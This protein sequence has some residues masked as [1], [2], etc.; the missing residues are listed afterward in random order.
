MRIETTMIEIK[1]IV[2]G[3]SV[4]RGFGL[5]NSIASY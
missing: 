2:I 4:Q 3:K 1:T 5:E